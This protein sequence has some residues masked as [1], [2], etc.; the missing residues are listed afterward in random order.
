MAVAGVLV[1]TWVA[2]WLSTRAIRRLADRMEEEDKEHFEDIERWARQ[3]TTFIRRSI[4]VVAGIAALF[5]LLRGLGLRGI[6]QLTW[7][8]VG[9]WLV[10]PG[11]RILLVLVSA[12]VLSRVVHLL[13]ARLPMFFV[14]PE[15]PLA[16]GAE[17]QKRATTISRGLRMLTTTVG[18]S[19][20]ILIVLRELGVDITPI[21]TGAG[22]V[23][24]AV[25]FGAQNLV[26]DIISG[27]FLIIEDQVRVG[28]VAVGND[29][30]GLVE[31]VNLRT[32]VLRDEAGTVHI[33][34]NG[35]VKTLANM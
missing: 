21:L 33:F 15:G 35:E 30:G 4:E 32:I 1:L 16:E 31:Q 17:R 7:E 5:V 28:D 14:T 25:G 19:I 24:L 26:R 18:M 22:I 3:L 27:F 10:G 34:P 2:L 20:A 29:Q 6:P 11:L 23:G 8:R 12:F 13:I 9:E